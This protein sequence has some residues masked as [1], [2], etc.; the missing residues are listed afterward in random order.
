VPLLKRVV[1][2]VGAVVGFRS[3][4]VERVIGV[5]DEAEVV[6]TAEALT[7]GAAEVVLKAMDVK[8]ETP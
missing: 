5:D 3:S 1:E 6:T 2:G 4:V 8:E 7:T